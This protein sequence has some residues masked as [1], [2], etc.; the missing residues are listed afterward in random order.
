MSTANNDRKSDFEEGIPT[1][2]EV[3]MLLAML[4]VSMR[5]LEGLTRRSRC[6]RKNVLVAYLGGAD[7]IAACADAA[8]GRGEVDKSISLRPKIQIKTNQQYFPER[9]VTTYNAHWVE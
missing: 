2:V 1:S 3:A 4:I 7:P 9:F 5:M 8:E 6:G